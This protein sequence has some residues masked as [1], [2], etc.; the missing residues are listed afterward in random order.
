M[1]RLDA[2]T[3]VPRPEPYPAADLFRSALESLPLVLEGRTIDVFVSPETPDLLVDP[4]LAVEILSN[5]VENAAR[6]TEPGAPIELKAEPD[7]L[8]RE[9]VRIWVLDRGPGV[10]A[11][12]RRAAGGRREASDGSGTGLGLEICRSL[13]RALGGAVVLADRPGGGTAARL[14]LPAAKAAGGFG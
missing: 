7:A 14:D 5:L 13:A 4:A 2:G 6:A 11:D 1:A 12:V 9:R 3:F 10:P 8:D